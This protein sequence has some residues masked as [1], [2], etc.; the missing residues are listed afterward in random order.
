MNGFEA[1]QYFQTAS[2]SLLVLVGMVCLGVG[3]WAG[4]EFMR[5]KDAQI[6]KGE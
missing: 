4:I 2:L 3:F 6:N 5:V 1:F